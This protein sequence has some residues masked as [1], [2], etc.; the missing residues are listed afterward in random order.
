MFTIRLEGLDQYKKISKNNALSRK[1]TPIARHYGIENHKPRTMVQIQDI[2]QKED[3]P[4]V[5]L[6]GK[7]KSFI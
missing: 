4:N 5:V 7:T 1:Q 6:V 3:N 2:L